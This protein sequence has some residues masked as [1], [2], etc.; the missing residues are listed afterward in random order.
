L[1]RTWPNHPY[2]NMEGTEVSSALTGFA[3]LTLEIGLPFAGAA[4]KDDNL[5]LPS[6]AGAA[7]PTFLAPRAQ[8]AGDLSRT[9]PML[10]VG[11]RGMRDFYPELIAEN[12]T[13]QGH[14]ARAHFLPIDLVS[15]RSD[16]NTVQLAFGLDSPR[17]QETLAFE[18]RKLV[19]P[20]ERIG[21]P[22]ILGM[23]DHEGALERLQTQL[24]VPVFEI[25]TLPPSVPGIRLNAALRR[26]LDTQGVRVEV[27]AEVVNFVS[28]GD[29]VV[30]LET[31]ASARP[32]RHLADRFLL[33][34]GGILGGGIDSDHTGRVWETVFNLPL[35]VPPNRGAWFRG[36]VLDPAGHPI[37][38]A[39]VPV[40][41][42]FQPVDTYG[43][44]VYSNVWAAGSLLAYADPIV[45]RSLE[46]IA[47]AT[48][49]AAAHHA[50]ATP[51]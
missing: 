43:K 42:Q 45:E 27:N 20:G 18:L 26:K 44:Q 46:G 33:A 4:K 13:K 41:R 1:Q 19:R 29:R 5:W 6:P 23:D 8:L 50:A 15:D 7:R 39:G 17:R 47:I 40:N 12:L 49:V 14:P 28:E 25:P 31:E 37:F 32:L 10:I 11:L 9:E 36:H 51:H 35:V 22:A 38:R 48:G 2:A 34:T 30:Y 24:G 21:L 3:D 16:T